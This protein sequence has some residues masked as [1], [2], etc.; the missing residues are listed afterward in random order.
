[1][2]M[3]QKSDHLYWEA[4]SR[5]FSRWE[6]LKGLALHSKEF[7]RATHDVAEEHKTLLKMVSLSRIEGFVDI[8]ERV[9]AG[10]LPKR[11]RPKGEWAKVRPSEYLAGLNGICERFGLRDREWLDA[12]HLFLREALHKEINRREFVSYCIYLKVGPES[13]L[14]WAKDARKRGRPSLFETSTLVELTAL[15]NCTVRRIVGWEWGDIANGWPLENKP[16]WEG[17]TRQKVFEVKTS[18]QRFAKHLEITL[19]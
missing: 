19:P 12:L 10:R 18:I 5:R 8:P 4:W 14:P 9:S 13:P 3:R 15:A 11:L 7:L 6:I 2:L 17:D 16:S 1:M